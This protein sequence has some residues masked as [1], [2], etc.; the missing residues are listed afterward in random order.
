[1][2]DFMNEYSKFTNKQGQISPIIYLQR[3]QKEQLN[4]LLNYH[5][6]KDKS[7]VIN[8][9]NSTIQQIQNEARQNH[10]NNFQFLTNDEI[11]DIL[12]KI[13]KSKNI[14]KAIDYIYSIN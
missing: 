13:N 6:N 14:G 9:V 3:N 7:K 1:M 2:N 8:L 11:T 12:T 10:V 4:K 5:Y